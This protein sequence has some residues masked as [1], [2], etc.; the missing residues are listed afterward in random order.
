MSKK[1]IAALLVAGMMT[2][3]V[4][5]GTLAWF[6]SNDSVT[7]VFN[8]G[9]TPEDRLDAGIEVD[10]EFPNSTD[11]EYNKPVLPGDSMVK[12]VWVESTANYDQ[13]VRAKLVKNFY[14]DDEVVTHWAEVTVDGENKIVYGDSNL[15]NGKPLNLSNIQLELNNDNTWSIESG[16]INLSSLSETNWYYYNKVL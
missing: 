14:Y 8:T 9:T 10:E 15:D 13:F 2:V 7:N 5:G 4:V 16:L 1:K 6:T 12:E 11:N 3:G